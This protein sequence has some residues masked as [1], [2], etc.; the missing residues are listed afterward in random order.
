MKSRQYGFTPLIAIIAIFI[1]IVAVIALILSFQNGQS[2]Q[3]NDGYKT[4]DYPPSP[5]P[6]STSTDIDTLE[7]ELESTVTGDIEADINSIETDAS[8]L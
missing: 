5:S 7:S 8:G 6:V 1:I 4:T 2:T 3:V